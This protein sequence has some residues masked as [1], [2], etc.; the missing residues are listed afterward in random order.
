VPRILSGDVQWSVSN[1]VVLKALVQHERESGTLAANV[2]L[3]W[4]YDPG[5]F[6]YFIANPS[7]SRETGS[8]AVYLL[9]VTWRWEAS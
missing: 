1:R 5:S 2:R 8:A 4:E 7:S 3:A 6:V 9:K